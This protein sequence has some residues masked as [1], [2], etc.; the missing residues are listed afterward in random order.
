M[1]TS[2]A[3]VVRRL[4]SLLAVLCAAVAAA[5]AASSAATFEPIPMEEP[6]PD[7][8]LGPDPCT[9]LMNL[10]GLCT[11]THLDP[12]Y[13]PPL[14]IDRRPST[15]EP[16]TPSA[17][18]GPCG[19]LQLTK[20]DGTPWQ[21]TFSDEFSG[22]QI[23]TSKWKRQLTIDG[24]SAFKV[25]G[26]M[27]CFTGSGDNA[28]VS[29]GALHLTVREEPAAFSCVQGG[30]KPP[31]TTKFTGGGVYSKDL[32]SQ[33]YGRFTVRA[34][35]PASVQR[36]LHAALWMWPDNPLKYGPWPMSG[37]ID[38]VEYYLDRPGYV[39]PHLHFLANP[40]IPK[41]PRRGTNSTGNSLCHFDRPDLFHDYTLVWT[42]QRLAIYYD[43]TLCMFSYP[44]ALLGGGNSVAPFD[45][46]FFMVLSQALGVSGTSN[47]YAPGVTELPATTKVD[48]VR[49]WK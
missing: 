7:S 41:N 21:C 49:V 16:S 44:K 6:L 12:A 39:V 11:Y 34:A 27:A 31:V 4:V 3:S 22:T 1:S 38:I 40:L 18:A 29:G 15:A 47:E 26:K 23:D 14:N 37:E 32:F 45:Q 33:A 36:G 46:P 2:L 8:I 25:D 28:S 19:G 13:A 43:G 20:E 30:N 42:P 10:L 5:P 9:S 35:F 17:S 24:S 48:W